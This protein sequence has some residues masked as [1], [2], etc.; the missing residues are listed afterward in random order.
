MIKTVYKRVNEYTLLCSTT[1]TVL[2]VSLKLAIWWKEYEI[3]A[4]SL[5]GLRTKEKGVTMDSETDR[6]AK[7]INHWA[8]RV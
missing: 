8:P 7:K 4:Q 5:E 6:D 1:M 2:T 3:D